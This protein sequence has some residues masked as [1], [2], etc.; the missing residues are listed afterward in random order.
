MIKI[1]KRSIRFSFDMIKKMW[2]EAFPREIDIQEKMR[3]K[4][5]EAIRK[6]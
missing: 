1:P 5:E 4:R 2:Y 6:K 3:L